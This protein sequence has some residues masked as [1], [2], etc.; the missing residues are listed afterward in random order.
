MKEKPEEILRKA[1]ENLRLTQAQLAERAK[2]SSRLYQRIESGIF[3]KFKSETIKL[4]D[5]IL[6]TNVY[7][8]I[9]EQNVPREMET[10]TSYQQS[11]LHRKIND[12]RKRTVPFYDADVAAG[13]SYSV[14]MTGITEPAG[15]MDVGDLLADSDAA[16][17]VYGNSMMQGYPPGCV[18]GLRKKTSLRIEPGSLYVLETEDDRYFKRLFNADENNKVYVCFSDNTYKYENG[19]LAGKYFY[20]PFEIAHDEVKQL[21]KVTG[22][23]KRNSNSFI[24][25][26]NKK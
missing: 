9:Y 21:F 2:I 14:E 1:R 23:I 20:P 7:E 5:D 22:V 25:N 6:G 19:P 3:P 24:V 18:I 13:Q 16:M 10:E 17:R 11:R 4:L 12:D 8:Q 15:T 26:K